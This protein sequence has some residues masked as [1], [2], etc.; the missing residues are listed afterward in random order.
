MYSNYFKS[1]DVY[2]NEQNSDYAIMIDGSWGCGKTYFV[3]EELIPY[4]QRDNERRIVYVSLFGVDALD[5][6]MDNISL[7]ILNIVS[8]ERIASRN[9]LGG[10]TSKVTEKVDIP[11]AANSLRKILGFV[12]GGNNAKSLV[13]DLS[14]LFIDFSKYIFIFDD[15]ERC[16][17]N[18]DVLLGMFSEII[19][20]NK[21]KIIVV[22]NEDEI[23]KHEKDEKAERYKSFKEKVF[24]VNIKFNQSISC[25]FDELVEKL[26]VDSEARSFINLSKSRIIDM[27]NI[28]QSS[29]IRTLIFA[30]KRFTELYNNICER[31]VKTGNEKEYFEELFNEIVLNV[32]SFSLHWKKH[33]VS[34][35]LKEF[36]EYWLFDSEYFN[37]EPDHKYIDNNYIKVREP[38]NNYICNLVLTD[39]D[40]EKIVDGY[41]SLKDK[42]ISNI[43]NKVRD[44]MLQDDDIAKENLDSV[45]KEIERNEY[46][47]IVYPKIL[48]KIFI[49]LKIFEYDLNKIENFKNNVVNNIIKRANEYEYSSWSFYHCESKEVNDFIDELYRTIIETNKREK[50]REWVRIFKSD[51]NFLENFSAYMEKEKG[52]ITKGGVFANV[53]VDDVT[54]RIFELDNK[55]I[56]EF[57]SKLRLVFDPRIGNLKDF[58]ADDAMFFKLL[59]NKL[60][61]KITD[62]NLKQTT[63]YLLGKWCEYLE[64]IY[65]H[66]K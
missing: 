46:R 6:L 25:V 12:P 29:N 32:F 7:G 10:L 37:K 66:L 9:F 19:N 52:Y 49:L 22:C 8:K 17:I 31:C 42:D 15:F 26:C 35:E 48:D 24:G 27:F 57:F 18:L 5:D 44:L 55:D 51:E 41:C 28:T 64:E 54:E 47:L 59:E 3:K 50:E 43:V 34:R 39:D 63:K 62:N 16:N 65:E 14:K 45:L 20:Q 21:S 61:I 23:L 53:E 4:L 38:I 2:L 60:R 13:T 30:I 40:I 11:F 1:I 36:E 56:I 33:N 58:Y